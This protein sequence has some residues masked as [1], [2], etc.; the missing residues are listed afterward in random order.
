MGRCEYSCTLDSRIPA[1][2][3]KWIV[4]ILNETELA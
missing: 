1:A 3:T 2:D 4:N